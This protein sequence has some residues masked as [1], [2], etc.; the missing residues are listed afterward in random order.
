MIAVL[1]G[2]PRDLLVALHF[3]TR[4]PLPGTQAAQG[5]ADAVAAFP[6]AGLVLGLSLAGLDQVLG[7]T[8]LPLFTR[9][10]LLVIALVLL[11][12]GLHLEGLMDTCDGLW[13]GGTPER[14]LAIMRDSHVGSYG[15]L[16]G[17]CT[18]LLKLGAL[19]A[20]PSS[21]RAATLILAPVLGRWV[22]VMAAAIFP[23]ARPDGLGAAFRL[24]V[25]W[26]RFGVAASI[27]LLLTLA[28]G[29][30]VGVPAWMAC[31]VATWLVG[32]GILHLIP[33]LTGDTYGALAELAEVVA[34]FVGAL[35]P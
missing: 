22:L 29:G 28:V 26:P 24:G 4:L 1:R 27:S 10:V 18:L 20:L 6:L 34:L 33:G 32:R 31:G 17:A 11:T 19:Q 7:F 35:V 23:P 16:G 21:H 9:N 14:R 25:T 12:G 8:A 30:D 15:V 5:P 3:L 2:L 13:G